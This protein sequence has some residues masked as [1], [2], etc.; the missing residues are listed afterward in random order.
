MSSNVSVY[1]PSLNI[2]NS[3]L[4]NTTL[5]T[6]SRL[7]L[8]SSVFSNVSHLFRR[9]FRIPVDC[10]VFHVKTVIPRVP[11]ILLRG[12]PFKVVR[13]IVQS[14]AIFMV[15]LWE[16]VGIWYESLRNKSVYQKL[17]R[18]LVFVEHDHFVPVSNQ[19]RLQVSTTPIPFR[20]GPYLPRRTGRI[21]SL[22]SFDVFHIPRLYIFA[23]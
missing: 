20:V 9:K 10:A 2:A 3:H 22:V 8:N 18:P 11:F 17:S 6:K 13:N 23:V 19:P 5:S 15:H 16:R 21:K 1:L 12:N 4:G 7:R 14:F